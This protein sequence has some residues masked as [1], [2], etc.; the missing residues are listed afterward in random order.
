M[1]ENFT[2]DLRGNVSLCFI[3]SMYPLE[4]ELWKVN[5]QFSSQPRFPKS[6]AKNKFCMKV[7]YLRTGS[8]RAGITGKGIWG[9]LQRRIKKCVLEL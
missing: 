8:P 3:L 1:H 5:G 6:S 7:V 9:D 4:Y 2:F